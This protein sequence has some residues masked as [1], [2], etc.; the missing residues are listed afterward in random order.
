M[1]DISQQFKNQQTSRLGGM[2]LQNCLRIP[3]FKWSLMVTNYQ[4]KER[5]IISYYIGFRWVDIYMGLYL[6]GCTWVLT[7]NYIVIQFM[8]VDIHDSRLEIVLFTQFGIIRIHSGDP[9]S[10]DFG[11]CKKTVPSGNLLHNYGNIH[12]FLMGKL[13]KLLEYHRF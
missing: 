13:W 1:V 10:R 4:Q 5:I 7:I 3:D 9:N 12:I 6:C 8:A 2:T 11:C